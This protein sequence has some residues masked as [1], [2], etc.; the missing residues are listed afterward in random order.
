MNGYS[1]GVAVGERTSPAAW[2]TTVPRAPLGPLAR[3]D[4]ALAAAGEVDHAAHALLDDLASL[5]GVRRVGVALAEGGGRR[6]RFTAVAGPE[7]PDRLEWC[8]IDAYD[9][10]PLTRVVRTG[11]PVSGSLDELEP[12]YAGLVQRER[13]EGTCAV[14]AVPLPGTGSPIGGLVVFLARPDHVPGPLLALLE[15]A[16]GRTSDAVHR[17]RAQ[18]TRDLAAELADTEAEADARAQVAALR[19]PPDPRAPGRARRFLR[20]ELDRWQVAADVVDTAQLCLS[21]VVTNAVNHA[22]TVADVRLSLL[23]DVLTVLV[24]DHGGAGDA[25]AP[26][27]VDVDDPLAVWGRGLA[28]VDALAERWGSERDAVGTT[29]WFALPVGEAPDRAS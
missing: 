25:V 5:P 29:V 24:R 10:V 6:L 18:H 26:A 12:L 16:A 14:A 3:L 8:H 17:I 15:A 9:D 2:G 19:L 13:S 23:D 11:E 4:V 28:L 22:H 1:R 7:V 27:P 21:E 20:Q